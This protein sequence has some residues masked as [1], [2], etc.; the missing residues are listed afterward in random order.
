MSAGGS[1]FSDILPYEVNLEIW[2]QIPYEK[3]NIL[4]RTV[5]VSSDSEARLVKELCA[6]PQAWISRAVR[7][8]KI[9]PRSF[10]YRSPVEEMLPL[11]GNKAQGKYVE[12]ISRRGIVS[13]SSYFLSDPE[14]VR[15]AILE[16]REDL[17]EKHLSR[18]NFQDARIRGLM[19]GIYFKVENS[20]PEL[21]FKLKKKLNIGVLRGG[22]SSYQEGLENKPISRRGGDVLGE[23]LSGLIAGNH[24]DSAEAD[25]RG[26]N[27]HPQ[28]AAN[29]V[30]KGLYLLGDLSAF[31][32]FRPYID[33]LILGNYRDLVYEG[34][35]DTANTET[36][37]EL[38]MGII[39]HHE[40]SSRAL[41]KILEYAI[42]HGRLD[43]VMALQR[44]LKYQL[45]IDLIKEEVI[46]M[47]SSQLLEGSYSLQ[48]IEWLLDN[49]WTQKKI[50]D[51]YRVG[52]MKGGIPRPP[53]VFSFKAVHRF[54]MEK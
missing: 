8:F 50:K 51:L 11:A 44:I 40:H 29:A 18:I 38:M 9:S 43:N 23:Y 34:I 32:R 41:S 25:L 35:A 17:L 4:C 26:D 28:V 30:L 24:L 16:D 7:V 1:V 19:M 27:Y 14:M 12:L 6:D 39:N 13:D 53:E 2:L 37:Q 22:S 54:L 21:R 47:L 31:D 42:E 46:V 20:D 15:R 52:Q 48:F 10:W 5:K 49:G 45:D 3:V 33:N 36:Y